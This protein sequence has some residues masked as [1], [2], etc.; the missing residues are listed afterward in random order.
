LSIFDL[1][2]GLW[3]VCEGLR[4]EDPQQMEQ[5]PPVFRGLKAMGDA[6]AK[7]IVGGWITVLWVATKTI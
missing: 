5:P 6:W 4:L 7:I 3:A 1:G 2:C